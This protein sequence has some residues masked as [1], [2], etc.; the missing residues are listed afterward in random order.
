M[1]AI[2]QM[3]CAGHYFAKNGFNCVFIF[4]F[5]HIPC[6]VDDD[7]STL[8]SAVVSLYFVH[9]LFLFG[10]FRILCVI[11]NCSIEFN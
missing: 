1:K 7:V 11:C 9:I 4:F 5:F 2:D 6:Q 3:L 8:T 10:W